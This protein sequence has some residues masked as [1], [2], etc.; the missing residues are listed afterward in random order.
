MKLK[1]LII[2]FLLIGIFVNVGFV[3]GEDIKY[4]AVWKYDTGGWVDSVSITPDGNYI[5]AGGNGIYLFNNNGD[6]LW[7]YE[8]DLVYISSVSITPDGKYIVAGVGDTISGGAIGHIN[9]GIYLFNNNGNLLWRYQPEDDVTSVAITPDGKYIAIGS[10]GFNDNIYLFNNN[11]DELWKY[12]TDEYWVNS[13]SITPDGNYIVAGSEDKNVYLFNREGRLLWKYETGNLVWSVSITPDGNYIVAGSWDGNVYLFNKEGRLLWK[14]ETGGAVESVSITPDG[15]YIVAGSNDSNV[16]LFNKEGRLLWKYETGGAVESVSITP[17]GNY[18]VAG[19]WDG[20]VYLFNREGRLLWNYWTG[21]NVRSVSITPNDKYIVAGNGNGSVYLFKAIITGSLYVDS[22]PTGAKI[23]INGSYKGTT[24]KT[25]TGLSPGEYTI[26]LKKDGYKDYTE[27]VYISPGDSKRVYVNLKPITGS[28]YVDS[29]PTGAKIYINGSYKGTTPKTI[30]GLS[31][32]EYTIT[33]KKDGY[34]DYTEIVYISPGLSKTVNAKLEAIPTININYININHGSN[35]ILILLLFIGLIVVWGG[36]R[37]IRKRKKKQNK[38]DESEKSITKQETTNKELVSDIPDFPA[39]LLNKYIPL[40]KLGEG[41]F[42]KVFKV[43]RKGGTQ[44]L[45]L[46]VPTFD[47]KAKKYLL[48][49]IKAW[50]NLNHPNIVKMYDAYEEP[51]PHIEMEYIEGYNLNGKL[52]KDLGEYPKPLNPKDAIKL[53]K[54]I[55]EGLKHAHDKNIIHRDIKPSNILLTQNLTPKITDWGLAKIGA[56]STTA[57]TTK[58]LTLI[59]SAPEQIDEEEYGKTDKRTDI[60]QLGVLFYELLTGR[61]PYEGITPTQVSLKIIN[62]NKKP[63]LP[64]KINPELSTFDGILEKLLAKKKEDRFQSID[65]FLDALNSLEEL[66]KEKEELRRTL[67]KTTQKLKISTDKKE[68]NRLIKDL[69]D[70][71]T[72]LALNCAK[73]N[74]KVGLLETL[75]SLENYVKSEEN[76]RELRGAIAHIEYL[77]KESIPLGKDTIEKLEVLL[78]RIKREWK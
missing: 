48:K 47:E 67:T 28:L 66:T 64:S 37:F 43:K 73:V 16:Y 27:I 31:P 14:Y 61:L 30:T 70:I 57:T 50:K 15:N 9:N 32:G 54:Q 51:I 1:N 42:G 6:L 39:E 26:T 3:F 69:I 19:S 4:T 62:P 58:G 41:G 49:E 34:K 33:L 72:K 74:D 56:K 77:I 60:Y 10:G 7:K 46:K 45:A 21:S 55:A 36:A 22:N 40:E 13:V 35:I 38:V 25:I 12:K 75:E 71:T 59:Y 23:Y 18:I 52:I 20:N 53:I 2:G 44:P 24:P 78:N 5:V 76:K 65:E 11:G 17:D 29:N 68:I 8:K 63:T